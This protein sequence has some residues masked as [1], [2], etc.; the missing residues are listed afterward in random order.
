M[1]KEMRSQASSRSTCR[2]KTREHKKSPLWL[3][4]NR[5]AARD[6]ARQF[7]TSIIVGV[8]INIFVRGVEVGLTHT[9]NLMK[10]KFREVRETSGQ[11]LDEEEAEPTIRRYIKTKFVIPNEYS[12]NIL[13][14]DSDLFVR[15]D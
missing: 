5:Q 12:E 6:T 15:K 13:I 3:D 2:Q 14:T 1:A 8:S 10:K 11:E 7:R 4:S 9:K